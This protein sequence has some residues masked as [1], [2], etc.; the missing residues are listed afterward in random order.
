M[1]EKLRQVIG[2][3]YI[4]SQGIRRQP[5]WMVQGVIFALGF[6]MMLFAWGRFEALTN[7]TIA[8]VV[9]GAWSQGVN[10]VAQNMGWNRVNRELERLVASPVTLPVYFAGV[11]VGTSPFMMPIMVPAVILAMIVRM[12]IL[13]LILLF[14]LSPMAL[15]LGAFLSLSIILRMKNPTNISA[16]T[17]P[18]S[19]MTTILPPVYYPVS[20]LPP[21]L[22]EIALA[23]PTVS[24]MEVGRWIVG[25]S[26]T[27]NALYPSA[28]LVGWLTALVV[29]VARRLKWGLE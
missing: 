19:T 12:K 10:I 15:V 3:A 4:E 1:I 29:L 6:I 21:I 22:K 20:I 8:Y 18:L 16:I 7:L 13:S 23:I 14:L 5:L 25:S 17:N 11:V 28:I 9:V 27:Y 2:V 26:P 24:L